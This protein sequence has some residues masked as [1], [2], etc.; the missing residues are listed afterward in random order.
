MAG[1][2]PDPDACATDQSEPE[3]KP[4]EIAELFKAPAGRSAAARAAPL[5]A[6]G[7]SRASGSGSPGKRDRN[8]KARE[9]TN[10]FK[11]Q[12]KVVVLISL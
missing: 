10:L 11:A 2:Q 7:D 5:G 12:M 8:K 1:S 9:Q 4:V 6:R 3:D